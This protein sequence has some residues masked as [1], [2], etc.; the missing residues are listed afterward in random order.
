MDV[1]ARGHKG[2]RAP[3]NVAPENTRTQQRSCIRPHLPPCPCSCSQRQE[4]HHA[5]HAVCE[6]GRIRLRR[7][8]I[9]NHHAPTLP[10]VVQPSLPC[11]HNRA[12]P[13]HAPPACYRPSLIHS[14]MSCVTPPSPLAFHNQWT[15]PCPHSDLTGTDTLRRRRRTDGIV[16]IPPHLVRTIQPG[17]EHE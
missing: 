9:Y 6:S 4:S 17:E 5:A 11:T 13:H 12:P 15:S 14:P 1:R 16:G 8:Y 3:G 10:Q 2:V 7:A